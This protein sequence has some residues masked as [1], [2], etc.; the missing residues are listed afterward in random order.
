MVFGT[1]SDVKREVE[2]L[3]AVLGTPFGNG[4]A[5]GPSNAMTPDIPLPNVR[6]MMEACHGR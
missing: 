1:P 6:A 2:R 5:V 4:F 3:I